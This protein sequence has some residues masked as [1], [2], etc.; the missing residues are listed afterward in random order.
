MQSNI[1]ILIGH[2]LKLGKMKKIIIFA[3]KAG[4]GTDR[5]AA[6]LAKMA[7]RSG[8]YSFVER[9][10]QSLIRGGHNFSTAAVS[11]DYVASSEAKADIVIAFDKESIDIHRGDL[12]EGGKMISFAET[13]AE[14]TLLIDVADFLSENNLSRNFGNNVMLGIAAAIAELSR[15]SCNS[16]IEEEFPSHK[17]DIK[18]I[19]LK[20][21]DIISTGDG[22]QSEPKKIMSGSEA[23]ALGAID[24]GMKIAFYYPMTPATGV[25]TELISKNG[26]YRVIQMEDEIA[27]AMAALGASYAGDVTLTG[28]SGGGL[29][30]MGEAVSL[31]G[32]AELPIVIYAAQRMGPSTGVPTYTEQGDLGAILN[33]GPGEFPKFA[34]V[35]GDA[36]ESYYATIDAFYIARKYQLPAFMIS[37]KHLAD[38]LFCVSE[39]SAPTYAKEMFIKEVAD[40][41][42]KRY[43]ITDDG[44]SPRIIP[45]SESVVRA[46][47]YEHDDRGHTT[48]D[49]ES[50]KIMNDKRLRKM[51]TLRKECAIMNPVRIFGK[52]KK[53]IIGSGSTKGAIMDYIS[54]RP[55]YRFLQV[56]HLAPFP[57]KEVMKEIEDADE[58]V[59]AEN[60]ATG[61]LAKMITA[62]TGFVGGKSVLRYDGRT[63]S[64]E[65]IAEGEEK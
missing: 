36:E 46:T 3:G 32:M 53:L 54:E 22:E 21:Y 50:I 51:E 28:S 61:L 20:G 49:P 6:I 4:Q 7:V 14:N 31:A 19:F 55:D 11:D 12:K 10:Y 44:I 40:G 64:K 24:A 37:D 33:L 56:I 35:P 65:M 59:I 5:T 26:N 60:N 47:S 1:A 57:A 62:E 16:V 23:V 8:K 38:S 27:V 39:F 30:L 43:A 2:K 48:E 45:G 58:V 9:D 41:E 18:K 15:T 52:G 17:E 63:L 25:F 34:I 42:Y 29:S 13:G